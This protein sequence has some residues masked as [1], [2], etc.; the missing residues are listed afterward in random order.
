MACTH[1]VSN[2]AEIMAAL[3]GLLTWALP[4]LLLGFVCG[5][6][7]ATDWLSNALQRRR[8]G[9]GQAHLDQSATTESEKAGRQAS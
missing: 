2:S 4:I 3:G 6:L 1:R 5:M 7:L 8:D 9:P